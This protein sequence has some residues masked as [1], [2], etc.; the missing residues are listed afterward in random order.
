MDSEDRGVV[1]Y[2]SGKLEIGRT[3]EGCWRTLFPH[4][5]P[6]KEPRRLT[7]GNVPPLIM[8]SD[9]TQTVL[10]IPADL[11]PVENYDPTVP[12]GRI[13][14]LRAGGLY[15]RATV[16]EMLQIIRLCEGLEENHREL[17]RDTKAQYDKWVNW[18]GLFRIVTIASLA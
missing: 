4:G 11:G 8:Q 6:I 1:F 2:L 10:L 3:E 15:L 14:S 13:T 7:Q 17:L 12:L 5:P 16:D 18:L 9:T